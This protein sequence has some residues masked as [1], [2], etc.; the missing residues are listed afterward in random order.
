MI[1]EKCNINNSDVIVSMFK[2]SLGN[3]YESKCCSNCTLEMLES[4]RYNL[5]YLLESNVKIKRLENCRNYPSDGIL[6]IRR[7]ELFVED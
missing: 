3:I 6:R 4:K 5:E 7:P 1:C 2:L